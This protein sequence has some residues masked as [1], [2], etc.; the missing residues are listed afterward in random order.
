[1]VYDMRYGRYFAMLAVLAVIGAIYE[2]LKLK[3][4]EYESHQHY[5]I[6]R[7]FLLSRGDA[8][9]DT[10]KPFLWIH[11]GDA[12]NA[13]WWRSFGSRNS[14]CANQPYQYVT[15]KSVVDRCGGDFAIC[16]IEDSSFLELLP[17][18]STNLESVADPIRSHLRQLALA[19]LLFT[20]GGL[21]LPS[22]FLAFR[23]CLP[24]MDAA[25]ASPGGAVF[26]ETPSAKGYG[27]PKSHPEPDRTWPRASVMGAVQGSAGMLSYRR[28][29]A[30]MNT[31]D[32]TAQPDF[33]GASSQWADAAGR[34]GQIAVVAAELLGTR[35]ARGEEVGIERLLGS[36]YVDLL[37]TAF[38]IAV[39]AEE[40]LR[41]TA[42]QWFARQSAAQALQSDTCLGKY[43]LVA[44]SP[45]SEVS[46]WAEAGGLS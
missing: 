39:P 14:R 11:A 26:G 21:V 13:R 44:S 16:I 27:P 12:I 1:M 40:I 18:W 17:E 15:M 37:P 5:G 28:M 10:A 33:L 30:D 32:Q 8:D 23:S 2:K 34:S 29:L 36:T 4:D 20:Y 46:I 38:G 22:S 19:E 43:L 45:D 7:K 24:I 41:R 25:K 3:D 35:D 9:L 31:A 6:V 42:Y